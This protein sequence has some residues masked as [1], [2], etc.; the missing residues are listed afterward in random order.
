LNPED[1]CG[2]VRPVQSLLK[3]QCECAIDRTAQFAFHRFE[4]LLL[5]GYKLE[6]MRM[7]SR[8]ISARVRT[9]LATQ[10]MW[11]ECLLPFAIASD[12]KTIETVLS[13]LA[14]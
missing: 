1:S 9:C 6:Q 11:K 14:A 13:D 12:R 10:S 5:M 4:M 8:R 7:T 3:T 2:F